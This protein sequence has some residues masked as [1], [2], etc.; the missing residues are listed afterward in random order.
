ME[1]IDSDRVSSL[2]EP[3][4]PDVVAKFACNVGCVLL[5]ICKLLCLNVNNKNNHVMPQIAT[6]SAA[7]DRMSAQRGIQRKGRPV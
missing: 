5:T 4:H 1:I 3:T 7:R 2:P 6:V